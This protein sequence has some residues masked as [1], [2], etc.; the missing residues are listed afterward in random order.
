MTN[1]SFISGTRADYGKIKPYIDFLCNQENKKV[2]VFTTGMNM[3]KKYGSTYKFIKSDLKKKCIIRVDKKFK[4]SS[5]ALE[6]A[7]IL[8]TYDNHLKKDKI[9]FV[10]VHGDRPEVLAAAQAAV[11]NNIPVC[12]IEAGDFSGSVDELIRHATSKL[13]HRFL[14]ADEMAKQTLL[15]MG[16]KE[17]SIFITGNSSLAFKIEDPTKKELSLLNSYKNYGVL[18]YHPV[19]T[20]DKKILKEEIDSL[21]SALD[22]SEKDYVVILP[23]NDLGS[24]IILKTYQKYA[25]N[26]K[27]HF[28]KSFSF[29]AFNYLLKNADFLIGNSSCGIKEAPFYQVP[30]ID[31]GCRQNNRFEHLNLKDFY[32]LNDLSKIEETILKI[33]NK[34]KK[35]IK[36]HYREAFFKTL[37]KVFTDDFFDVKIQKIFSKIKS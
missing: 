4:R 9:D 10:F 11:F 33:Q 34:K 6:T 21:M 24:E 35:P 13:S 25:T 2:F 15:Q 16:E 7:H 18:I 5:T 31:I 29:N 17:D 3:L 27:F 1:I 23:N 19:T 26:E 20:L 30:V 32:H 28:I 36:Y 12:H 8:K 14:V 22:K 37:K